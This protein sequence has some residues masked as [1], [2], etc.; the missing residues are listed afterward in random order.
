MGKGLKF[1]QRNKMNIQNSNQQ[2]GMHKIQSQKVLQKSLTK[3]RPSM[4]VGGNQTK[5]GLTPVLPKT[6]MSQNI[7]N[8]D[9]HRNL[10]GSTI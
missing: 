1:P 5:S 8:K 6:G 7:A 3:S 2:I 10:F 9:V 4:I